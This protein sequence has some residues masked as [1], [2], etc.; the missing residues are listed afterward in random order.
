M[1][2]SAGFAL[3]GL[4]A[5]S[6]PPLVVDQ[7]SVPALFEEV[8]A[9]EARNALQSQQWLRTPAIRRVRVVEIN[10]DLLRPID[11]GDEPYPLFLNL[12]PDVGFRI[13]VYRGIERGY[14]YDWLASTEPQ[15]DGR[16]WVEL[17]VN[18]GGVSVVFNPRDLAV[19][20]VTLHPIEGTRYLAVVEDDG[21]F[22]SYGREAHVDLAPASSFLLS[23]E[24]N[25]FVAETS[26]R[27]DHS[28]VDFFFLDESVGYFMT[29]GGADQLYPAKLYKTED[30]GGHWALISGA[31][32]AT[33]MRVVFRTDTDGY[34]WSRLYRAGCWGDGCPNLF[35]TLDGGR[36]WTPIPDPGLVWPGAILKATI[37]GAL[38][39]IAG[40]PTLEPGTA[41]AVLVQSNDG[42]QTWSDVFPFP[43]SYN[44]FAAATAFNDVLYVG[45]RGGAIYAIDVA[46]G[47]AET[48]DVGT[49]W[50]IDF[51]IASENVIVAT[52]SGEKG[53][54]V[55]RSTD[56]GA[57]WTTVM[58][59]YLSLVAA[60][61]ADE[62]ILIVNKGSYG[63]SDT[64]GT[65]DVIAY[66]DDGGVTWEEST[67]VGSLI[68]HTFTPGVRQSVSRRAHKPLLGDRV[69]TVWTRPGN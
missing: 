18:I 10:S 8:G 25:S 58:E 35:K 57:S 3:S 51:D 46:T 6:Q 13:Y 1:L 40:R 49:E 45:F 44:G 68:H 61:S 21:S 62:L 63:P 33:P 9:D 5:H 39:G 26:V 19:G 56:R 11:D 17:S 34:L 53:L 12:F 31:L 43:E 29:S 16:R 42:G 55:V 48:I 36:S 4:D 41:T 47:D 24:A 38:F 52:A 28:A 23:T 65:Q 69:L 7:G 27:V 30:G 64:A 20:Q 2:V 66:S 59:G 22:F 14:G 37:D 50:L 67:L 60:P 32:P 15:Y 54:R